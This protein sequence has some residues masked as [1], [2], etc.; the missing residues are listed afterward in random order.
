MECT[1]FVTIAILAKDKAH[2][3]PLYLRLIESQTYPAAR[4]KLYIRTNNNKD[5]TAAVLEQWIETVRDKYSEIYYDASD[6]EERVQD[7][8]PHDWNPLKLSVLTR[9]RQESVEWAKARG[10]DYFVVDCDNFIISETLENLLHTGLPVIGP[11]LKNGDNLLSNYANFHFVTDEN[12]YYK[13]SNLYFEILYQSIKGLIE[14]EVIHCTY[15]VRSEVLNHAT[16]IDGSGRYDYV[17]FSDALRKAGIP[18]YIDNRRDYGK[19][20]FCNT[21]EEFKEKNIIVG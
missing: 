11:L 12:G 15:L 20:T 2:V 19:L 18:Q 6:V 7:Y 16:Y 10:T 14:V 8:G 1:D 17:I 9:L 3:L 4:I 21:E 13:Y 5:N